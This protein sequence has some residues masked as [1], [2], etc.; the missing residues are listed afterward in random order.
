MG[1]ARPATTLLHHFPSSPCVFPSLKE[2]AIWR[3]LSK[4]LV[5]SGFVQNLLKSNECGEFPALEVFKVR[6]DRALSNLI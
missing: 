5:T 4:V 6:L 3:S 2:G 1:K